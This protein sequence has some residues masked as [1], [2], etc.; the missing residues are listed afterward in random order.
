MLLLFCNKM[1][2]KIVIMF[3]I[4]QLRS[5][6]PNGDID[7]IANYLHDNIEI[8]RP[9]PVYFNLGNFEEMIREAL[10]EKNKTFSKFE[11]VLTNLIINDS[12]N[13]LFFSN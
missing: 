1:I 9:K 10:K 2:K 5:I 3:F 8:L 12:E 13:Y 11:Q 7:K 6:D 4:L